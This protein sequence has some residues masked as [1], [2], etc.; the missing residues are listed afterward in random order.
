MRLTQEQIQHIED[1]LDTRRLRQLDIRM[2]VLDHISVS[3]ETDIKEHSLSFV[4]AFEIQRITWDEE[5][6]DY[7]SYWLG[8]MWSGPK[9]MINKCVRL[10][11]K[12]YTNVLLISSL[13][14]VLIYSLKDFFYKLT[15]CAL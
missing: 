5:L 8:F 1:Y 6:R 13:I 14:L 2:E 3:I 4:D 7:S 9:I 10:I 12:T 11:K 15:R